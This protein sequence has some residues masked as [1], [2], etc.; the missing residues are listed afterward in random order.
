MPPR[1]ERRPPAPWRNPVYLATTIVAYHRARHRPDRAYGARELCRHLVPSAAVRRSRARPG[2][3]YLGVTMM[4]AEGRDL[5]EWIEFHL[6]QGVERV[7][8]Y[9]N[10]A[11]GDVEEAVSAYVERGIVELTPWS[12]VERQTE[13]IGDAFDR[14]RDDVRWLIAMDIDEFLFCPTGERVAD[15][16]TEYECYPAVAVHWHMFGTSGVAKRP[17][18]SDVLTTFV[19]R[20]ADFGPRSVNRHIKSIVDPWYAL[21]AP[22]PDPHHRPYRVGLA[23]N[24]TG[25]PVA[26]PLPWPI[27]AQRLRINHYWSK[28]KAESLRKTARDWTPHPLSSLLSDNLNAVEDR[29]ILEVR[30]R[31]LQGQIAVPVAKYWPRTLISAHDLW[32]ANREA[33]YR[34]VY[35][36]LPKPWRIRLDRLPLREWL[37]PPASR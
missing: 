19:R 29:T 37:L 1:S 35:R 16:L 13:A 23:V 10:C 32:L 21:K 15:V 14:K 31:L 26:G 25:T 6:L 18:G 30:D 33:V 9:D 17:E 12:E 4:V 8:L 34:A 7:Y 24:E 11:T 3:P 36:R 27:H 22:P 5:R 28:S 20:S 2:L